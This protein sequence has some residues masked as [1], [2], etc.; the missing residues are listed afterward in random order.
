MPNS[1]YN[2]LNV[3]ARII[4]FGK[5]APLKLIIGSSSH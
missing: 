5:W 3:I 1:Y 4:S 2:G